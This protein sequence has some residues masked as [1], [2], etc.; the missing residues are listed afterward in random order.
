MIKGRKRKR[1][2]PRIKSS[3]QLTTMK[4]IILDQAVV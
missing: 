4:L 1:G 3:W 2:A